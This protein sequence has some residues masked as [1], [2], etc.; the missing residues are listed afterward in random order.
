MTDITKPLASVMAAD[1]DGD[2]KISIGCM[3]ASDKSMTKQIYAEALARKDTS[4]GITQWIIDFIRRLVDLILGLVDIKRTER[5]NLDARTA[6]EGFFAKNKQALAGILNPQRSSTDVNDSASSKNR[7]SARPRKL[8]W[9]ESPIFGMP[10][11]GGGGGSMSGGSR[12][13]GQQKSGGGKSYG[14]GGSRD[15]VTEASG[16]RE[17]KKEPRG[18]GRDGGFS[19]KGTTVGLLV[20]HG[21]DYFLHKSPPK[22]DAARTKK[23][24]F[25]SIR[26]DDGEVETLWGKEL[27]RLMED[28]K[29]ILNDRISLTLL[30]KETVE[31]EV[32]RK[33]ED[34]SG[35]YEWVTMPVEKNKWVLDALDSENKPNPARRGP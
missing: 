3:I 6:A 7:M 21:E 24:Y 15:S 1:G 29:P 22:E 30:G 25:V 16:V 32:K 33:K 2:A 18:N 13:G 10:S 12:G 31:T 5:L 9:W 28:E 4:I 35:K 17:E 14:G 34:G 27:K 8:S 20:K 26:T 19:S 23:S 11:A